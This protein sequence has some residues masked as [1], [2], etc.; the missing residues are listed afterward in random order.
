MRTGDDPGISV[1]MTNDA[2]G[3]WSLAR[4]Q[5]GAFLL[6]Q[7]R[8]VGIP[9]R[10]LRGWVSSGLL[11]RFGVRTLRTSIVEHD[12]NDDA[13]AHLLDLRPEGWV[14]NHSAAVTHEFD[15]F[16]RHTGSTHIVLRRGTYAKRPGVIVHTSN[17]LPITDRVFIAG[18]PVTSP[19][20]TLV[21]LA[22]SES[23]KRLTA[24]LDGALRDRLL[25]ED[26]LLGRIADLRTQGRYGVPK[27]LSVIMG[28]EASRGGHSFLE[29]RFLEVTSAAGLP[30]PDVQRRLAKVD[31]HW[32]RVDCYYPHADLVVELLGYRWH[33][34]KSQMARDAERVNRLVL[35]GRG[36]LQY[37]FEHVT[38]APQM[39]VET[40]REALQI[41]LRQTAS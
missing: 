13:S 16:E 31:E 20:R 34:S 29:R 11:D 3:L 27:L 17:D 22:R 41:R 5:H 4:G 24:V 19:T 18:V 9:D 15:T 33:R 2:T 21:D 14:S 23:A 12:A 7:A 1:D 8:S 30:R 28:I 25:T 32:I 38:K 40:V 6:E 39:V 36:V 35:Q 26:L 10:V 37:T